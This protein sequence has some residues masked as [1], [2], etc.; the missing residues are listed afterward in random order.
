MLLWFPK[1]L[2]ENR[3]LSGPAHR[4]F[5]FTLTRFSG[6]KILKNLRSLSTCWSLGEIAY[7]CFTDWTKRVTVT[8]NPNILS[9]KAYANKATKPQIVWLISYIKYTPDCF[10]WNSTVHVWNVL[11][12]TQCVEA[13]L[14]EYKIFHCCRSLQALGQH[15]CRGACTTSERPEDLNTQSCNLATSPAQGMMKIYYCS[16]PQTTLWQI[17]FRQE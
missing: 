12:L 2:R 16:H 4:R 1:H 5:R 11:K 15:Y 8:I 3:K 10:Q 14:F 7:A 13:A 17:D 6:I 9:C